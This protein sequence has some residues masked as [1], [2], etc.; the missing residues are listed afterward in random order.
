M[1]FIRAPPDTSRIC[2]TAT[3][4]ISSQQTTRDYN[5]IGIFHLVLFSITQSLTDLRR[6]RIWFH[7]TQR[8]SFSPSPSRFSSTCSPSSTGSICSRWQRLAQSSDGLPRTGR[9]I[10][11]GGSSSTSTS[12]PLWP[13]CLGWLLATCGDAFNI[14]SKGGNWRRWRWWSLLVLCSTLARW[15]PG[16]LIFC[17]AR[18]APWK[19]WWWRCPSVRRTSLELSP[20][21]KASQDWECWGLTS[22]GPSYPSIVLIILMLISI[23]LWRQKFRQRL[24]AGELFGTP[25]LCQGWSASHCWVTPGNLLE[26]CSFEGEGETCLLSAAS[27]QSG[28]KCQ[29]PPS[30]APW[31]VVEWLS[32]DL[33]GPATSTPAFPPLHGRTPS[34]PEAWRTPWSGRRTSLWS[35]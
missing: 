2:N 19:T 33:A 29:F 26:E 31:L 14:F 21:R 10:G 11:Q 15:C 32:K 8:W 16:S 25:G 30:M 18:L 4:T 23:R 17:T 5:Y 7:P 35:S 24:S 1:G 3:P 6:E 28:G 20:S 12:S 27:T 34:T 22:C 9:S 13:P